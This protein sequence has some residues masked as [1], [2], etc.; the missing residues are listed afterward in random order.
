VSVWNI[1]R[2]RAILLTWVTPEDVKIPPNR[3]KTKQKTKPT[4][5]EKQTKN[6]H[7]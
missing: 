3:T 1:L 7:P 5:T 4:K 6:P 2:G